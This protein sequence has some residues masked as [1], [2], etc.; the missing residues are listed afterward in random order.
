MTSVSLEWQDVRYVVH[1]KPAPKVILDGVSGKLEV[2][3]LL[4]IM[5]PSGS[6]K[7]SLLNALAGR[8]PVTNKEDTLAGR[9]LVGGVPQADMS[10]V[11]AYVMQ[12]DNLFALSTVFETLMFAA[13]L[14]LPASVSLQEKQDV[15]NA[16]IAKLGLNPARD[17]IIG[18]ARSRG[19]S[20]GER[21][22]VSIGV[23]LLHNPPMVFLDEPTSGLDSFQAQS[24]MET[25]RSLASSG[26][27][28]VCSIHQVCE[29]SSVIG[30]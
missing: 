4:A 21:K 13:Q 16:V 17:T 25:L 30:T 6:G 27:T 5:G 12:D 9:V 19:V 10:K 11:S 28:V 7:T 22:R 3:K 8:V 2:G 24:V 23:E 15:V 14:R 1:G 18:N 20:G 29:R 26:H